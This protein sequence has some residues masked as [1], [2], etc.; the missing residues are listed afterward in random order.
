MNPKEEAK[1]GNPKRETPKRNPQGGNPK[2]EILS[3]ELEL[4]GFDISLYLLEWLSL[5]SGETSI[6]HTSVPTLIL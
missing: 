1:G 3:P 6:L 4:V 2:E 5:N